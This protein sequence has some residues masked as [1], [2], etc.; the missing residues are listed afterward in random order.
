MQVPL[1]HPAQRHHSARRATLDHR[2]ILRISGPVRAVIKSGEPDVSNRRLSTR[3]VTPDT[4]ELVT[5]IKSREASSGRHRGDPP[6]LEAPQFRTMDTKDWV[7]MRTV[8]A[9]DAVIDTVKPAA[10]RSK[11]QMRF[12]TFLK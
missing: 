11:T 10:Q 1:A 2:T 9:D 12:M 6:Q 3:L 8:F 4:D 7:A 5:H